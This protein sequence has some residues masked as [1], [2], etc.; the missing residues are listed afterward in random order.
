M[1]RFI[2]LA[3]ITLLPVITYAQ[4]LQIFFR[5]MVTFLI[6]VVLPVLLGI[7]FL[8]FVINVIRFFVFGAAEQEAREKAKNLAIYS[9]AA[10]LIIVLF[11]GVVNLF[12]GAI[13]LGGVAQ[14]APDYFQGGGGSGTQ[15]NRQAT[16]INLLPPDYDDP[17]PALPSGPAGPPPT[18]APPLP[19][20]GTGG[21]N[22]TL[23]PAPANSNSTP[24]GGGSGSG[25]TVGCQ[26]RLPS[27]G[28][29]FFITSPA[30]C[31]SQGG[32]TVSI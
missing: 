6:S 21:G 27:G 3:S 13:G 16:P 30:D 2:V 18:V 12:V 29:S 31:S 22:Q 14:P 9:V 26:V 32:Q 23:P 19:D 17:Q 24:G 10:F 1:Y 4:T 8:F 7:G 5:N 15:Q 28:T 25:N 11:W 20:T